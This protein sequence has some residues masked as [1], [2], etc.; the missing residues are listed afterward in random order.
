MEWDNLEAELMEVEELLEVEEQEQILAEEEFPNLQLE[1]FNGM[2]IAH[3][4]AEPVIETVVHR[5]RNQGPMILPR[6]EHNEYLVT[7][8]EIPPWTWQV[9]I[10]THIIFLDNNRR[11]GWQRIIR[12][13]WEMRRQRFLR[14]DLLYQ[15]IATCLG[16][17]IDNPLSV[18][19]LFSLPMKI[20]SWNCQGAGNAK[21]KRNFREF[22][23]IHRPTVVYLLE[24][25]VSQ[26]RAREIA[27]T[28]GFSR[29]EIAPTDGMSG[30]VWM[31][32]NEED[33]NVEIVLIEDQ[34]I[35]AVIGPRR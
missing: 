12:T 2:L 24:T 13:N 4:D 1:F 31:L 14:Q 28:L 29:Y 3:W 32:W 17:P 22:V 6:I 10:D 8:V 33:V 34:G 15:V 35:H 23:R 7:V 5:F 30:G 20:V 18:N 27:P 11:G 21:F 26:D 9:E 25:R 16:A 19:N